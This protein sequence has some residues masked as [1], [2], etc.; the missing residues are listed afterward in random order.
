MS[1]MIDRKILMVFAGAMMVLFVAG[2]FATAADQTGD[3]WASIAK[4]EFGASRTNVAVV[5]EEIRTAPVKKYSQYEDKLLV[6]IKDSSA[7]YDSKDFACRMLRIVGSEKCVPVMGEL[8]VDEKLSHMA[9]YAVQGLPFPSVDEVLRSVL[10]KVQG[11]RKIGVIASIAARADK[12]A[13]PF[14]QPLVTDADAGVAGAAI[15]ALGRIG[16]PDALKILTDTKVADNLKT[17]V[18]ESR[19]MCADAMLAKGDSGKAAA[20]YKEMMADTNPRGIRSAAITGLAKADKENALPV[21]IS[22]LKSKDASCQRA[23]GKALIELKGEKTAKAL[24]TELCS[25]SPDAQVIAINALVASRAKSAAAD[26]AKM[27]ASS[28]DCVKIAAIQALVELGDASNVELLAGL[29]K[30]GGDV[31]KAAIDSLA[32][33]KGKGVSEA[34]MKSLV[35]VDAGSKATLISSL[36]ERQNPEIVADLMK[37]VDDPDESVR[38]E[39]LKSLGALVREKEIPVLIGMML[40]T[41][42]GRVQTAGEQAVQVACAKL[43][44]EKKRVEPLVNALKGAGVEQR[45]VLLHCLGRLGGDR[46]LEIVRTA[47]KDSDEKVQESAVRALSDWTDEGAIP[48]LVELSRNAPKDNL[49]ILAFRGYIRLVSLG[50]KKSPGK[51]AKTL[52]DAMKLTF[53]PDEKKLVL[54]ALGGVADM[55]AM[56]AAQQCMQDPA[57]SNEAE[58]ACIK[59]AQQFRPGPARDKAMEVVKK[60]AET[61][62]NPNIRKQATSVMSRK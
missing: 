50:A 12:K 53:R 54:G 60:I 7:T 22:M 9:R 40:K 52:A 61:T 14:L 32:R 13:I 49:K 41:N 57:F 21:V 36:G 28:D 34:I 31:G 42:P 24:L 47:S 17:V 26:V 5:E 11:S 10:G 59:I 35:N 4:Y 6:L 2:S 39:A 46:A 58:L 29:V 8:L 62:K 51:T 20:I 38:V 18:M 45:A 15:A 16:G 44:S 3:L 48:D 27:T 33:L 55:A 37:Y 23:A 30:T 19:L 1:N 56:N 25:L 43:R